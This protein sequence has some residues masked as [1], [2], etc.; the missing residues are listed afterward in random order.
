MDDKIIYYKFEVQTFKNGTKAIS[1]IAEYD[2]IIDAEVEFHR[3]LTYNM[4]NTELK[5]YLIMII[6]QGGE[7]VFNKWWPITTEPEPN[8]PGEE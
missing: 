6:D 7:V 3:G 8:E 5:E 2:N 4:K 1:P